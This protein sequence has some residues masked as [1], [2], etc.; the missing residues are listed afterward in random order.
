MKTASELIAIAQNLIKQ[1]ET[2][3]DLYAGVEIKQSLAV[4]LAKA[5]IESLEAAEI[6][7]WR[8]GFPMSPG[9]YLTDLGYQ[10]RFDGKRFDTLSGLVG[11]YAD[12]PQG[13]QA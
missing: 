6:I 8:R 2:L 9:W 3:S 12:L 4:D 11:C 5:I 7:H 10:L 13:P 1:Y